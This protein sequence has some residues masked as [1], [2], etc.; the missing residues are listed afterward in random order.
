MI[1]IRDTLA[2]YKRDDVRKAIVAHAE[3]KEVAVRFAE[4]FGKRP[5][6]LKYENDVL[7]LVKQGALS[8]HCSEELWKNPLQLSPTMRKSEM[9]DLRIGFD[10]IIDID[11]KVFDYSKIAAH[12]IIKALRHYGVKTISIKFSGNK[13]FHIGVPFECFPDRINNQPIHLLFPEAPKRIALFLK[14]LITRPVSRAVLRLEKDIES[15]TQKLGM[16]RSKLIIEEYKKGFKSYR[17]N[18]DPFIEIDTILISSR[19]LYRMPYSFHE[20]SGLISIPI[21]PDRILTFKKEQAE[22]K[23]IKDIPIFLDRNNAKKGELNL[24]L[25]EAF[26]FQPDIKKEESSTKSY[27]SNAVQYA[28]DLKKPIP[29]E[30]FPDCIKKLLLGLEDGRKRGVLILINFLSCM[31]W[32]HDMI[33]K[34]INEWNAK[35][36][37]PL[38]E[39][40]IVG[41]LRYHKQQRKQVMPPN[42]ENEAYYKSLGIYCENENH[43]IIKNPV[44]RVKYRLRSL[45]ENQGRKKKTP[46][47]K[48]SPEKKK[49]IPSEQRPKTIREVEYSDSRD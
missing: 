8:F 47:E 48:P 14:H 10:L 22:P 20:K 12:Y 13:G 34:R 27:G 28:D 36:K 49:K 24:L 4:G 31:N 23:N 16:D 39:N 26:D 41:Q 9:E 45:N 42:C 44:Q 11:C 18:A 35:N 2:F 29:E 21:D 19:H 32:D 37:E 17:L 3:H 33:E 1:D 25:R 15:I 38:R 30:F 6:I 43:R 40:Y 5:D 7:E 46:E